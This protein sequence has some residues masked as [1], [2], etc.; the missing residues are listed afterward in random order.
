MSNKEKLDEY[1]K[2][3]YDYLLNVAHNITSRQ[4]KC[5]QKYNLL[6]E[7]IL[8][9]YD[10][11]ENHYDFLNSDLDFKRYTA[12]YLKQYYIWERNKKHTRKKDNHIFTYQPSY[13]ELNT[14]N[15]YLEELS[16]TN[17]S[18]DNITEQ[19]IYLNAEN[20]NEVTKLFLT[21]MLSNGIP[22]EKGM[23]VNRIKDVAKSLDLM[24]YQIFDMYYLQE[25]NCLEIFKEMRQHNPQ[26][27]SYLNLLAKQKEVKQKIIN[28]LQW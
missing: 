1:L 21:D 27:M 17:D 19:L 9:M 18:I 28:K 16:D 14:S 15:F 2:T 12:K 24:E 4:R 5:D 20:T 7:V 23:M 25:L 13:D 11:L 3:N 26:S 22:I 6:H 10:R 8:N